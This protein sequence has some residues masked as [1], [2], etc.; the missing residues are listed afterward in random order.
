[1]I[2]WLLDYLKIGLGLKVPLVFYQYSTR[3]VLAALFSLVFTILLGP[4]TIRILHKLKTGRSVRVEG[5]D[6]LAKIHEKKRYI[7]T[8]GGGL[9]LLALLLSILLFSDLSSFFTRW[10]IFGVFFLGLVGGID[11]YLKMREGNAK[12]IASKVKFLLQLIFSALFAMYLLSSA[13]K[14]LEKKVKATKEQVVTLSK[15]QA[16]TTKSLYKTYFV[17]FKKSPLF[18][19]NGSLMV[20]GFFVTIVVVTGTSNAVNL[21]DGLDG[22]ASGLLLPVTFVLAVFAFLSNHL[23]IANYLNIVYIPGSGE[24]GVCLSALAGAV[25]G[26]LWFNGQ[27]AQVFMGDTGSLALGG[28]VGMA[29][30]MLRR[31][32][33]LA[34]IGFV[35]VVEAL[36][37]IL[38]V[39]SYKLRGG[40]RIFRC[41]PLH[42]HFEMEGW[43][44]SKVVLRFWMVGFLFALIGLASIKF[45]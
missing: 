36:S 9:I 1:M 19:L 27:P 33:L 5:C 42:H 3:M 24:V 43:P 38:Q 25:L 45:Q 34:V 40:K 13:P 29:A 32:F 8:M 39:A 11:D 17:P 20:I 6:K 31:E 7:P 41:A 28:L 35:F 15:S 44:E 2:L 26:F 16:I 14:Q 12:G 22:L 37:V 10:F 30:V 23:S 4:L 21:S 18:T